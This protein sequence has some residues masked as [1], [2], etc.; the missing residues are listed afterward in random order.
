MQ[1]INTQFTK[2]VPGVELSDATSLNTLQRLLTSASGDGN[3][4]SVQTIE[5]VIESAGKFNHSPAS[6]RA[7]ALLPFGLGYLWLI[8]R[9]IYQS[10]NGGKKVQDAPRILYSILFS[11]VDKQEEKETISV[12]S[13]VIQDLNDRVKVSG[14]IGKPF[15]LPGSIKEIR[16]NL[17]RSIE[18]APDDSS[19][20]DLIRNW[21]ILLN[22][23]SLLKDALNTSDGDLRD[24][25]GPDEA[26][27]PPSVFNA[28]DSSGIGR[29]NEISQRNNAHEER[30]EITDSALQY[31]G[32]EISEYGSHEEYEKGQQTQALLL[33]EQLSR[34]NVIEQKVQSKMEPT[35]PS[36]ISES[37]S[38]SSL[39]AA[40][41]STEERKELEHL[42]E[43]VEPEWRVNSTLIPI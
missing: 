31:T 19:M 43:N 10:Y 2:P 12:G 37:A 23:P 41:T 27:H 36:D 9:G 34:S 35:A 5:E 40:L 1:H 16:E 38:A 28:F 6:E 13:F 42:V 29:N 11:N 33:L 4:G 7:A 14:Q 26:Q 15:Y 18:A 21:R 3:V 20:P 8:A 24:S 22:D 39:S 32:N 25:M 17:K 30:A